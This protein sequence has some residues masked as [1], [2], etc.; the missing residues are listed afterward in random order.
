MIATTR[1]TR[2]DDIDAA[3]GQLVGR[4]REL[5][6]LTT[7][8]EEALSGRGRLVLIE[9]EPGMGKSRLA[10]ARETATS[11]LARARQQKERTY[12]AWALRVLGDV[13]LHADSPESE[14]AESHYRQALAVADE[15]GM[16]PLVAHCHLGLG[17]LYRKVGR[18]EQA[19]AELTTAA[20]MYRAMGLGEIGHLLSCQR[21]GTFCEGY[22]PRIKL[23]R[24]QTIMQGASHCDFDYTFE[25]DSKA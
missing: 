25:E 24:T 14:Q 11:V 3:C 15:L 7:A 21:D 9:G 22:D 17:T 12:E 4:V 18:N 1:R 19:Q 2:G 16:R 8:L 10:D 5:A 6:A 20:E 13:A 23:Q